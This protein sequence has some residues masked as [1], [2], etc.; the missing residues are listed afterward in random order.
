MCLTESVQEC[1]NVTQ[2]LS[3]KFQSY[4]Y[5]VTLNRENTEEN[6]SCDPFPLNAYVNAE[7]CFEAL[8][9][10]STASK[11]YVYFQRALKPNR[12]H[13]LQLCPM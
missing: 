12:I 6:E 3:P 10:L 9:P 13:T 8:T 4:T 1:I 5:I 2:R 11:S 7:F